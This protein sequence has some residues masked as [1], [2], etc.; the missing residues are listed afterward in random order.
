MT[1][2]LKGLFLFVLVTTPIHVTHAGIFSFVANLFA[3][4]DS[5]QEVEEFPNVQNMALLRASLNPD[6]HTA[7]GGG[8]V[9]IIDGTSLLSGAHASGGDIVIPSSD[10]ISLYVVHEGDSLSQIA[11]MF[12]VSVNT[13]VWANNLR[14]TVIAPGQTL[15]ILPISGVR[16]IVKKGDTLKTIAKKYS[17]DFEEVLSYNDLSE[18]SSLAIGDIVTVPNGE[19]KQVAVSSRNG[20]STYA[21]QPE[22]YGYYKWPVAGGVKTQGIHGYNAV[23]IGAPRG[24]SIYA[25]ASGRV[26]LSRTGG[27][28]GGYGNYVVIEH[29]NGT[30]TLYAHNSRNIVATGQRVVQGQTIGYIGSTGNSTG[31]HAHFEIRGARNPF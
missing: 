14:G 11:Q 26:V 18:S 24:A 23:D 8:A 6:G 7:S 29:S 12:G 13:I 9:T 15:V 20:R 3:G 16:H 22:Y 25:S 27:W 19:V 17:G 5:S 4:E 1:F 21:S 30:Q 31:P 2:V 10:Q 28:N